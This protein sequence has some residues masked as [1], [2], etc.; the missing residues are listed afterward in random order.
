MKNFMDKYCDLWP[1]SGSVLVAHKGQIILSQGYGMA[2]HEYGVANTPQTK[3]RICSITKQFTAMAIMILYEKGLLDVND[4]A[5]GYLDDFQELDERITI[6]HLLTHTSGLK[7]R[8]G[9]AFEKE[10]NASISKVNRHQAM[11]NAYRNLPLLCEPGQEFNYSNFGYF[12]LACIVE[13]VSGV[14]YES[15][16]QTH[17]FKPLNMVNTGVERDKK[18]IENLATGYYLTGDELIRFKPMNMDNAFGSGDIY[19]TVED[20]YLWDR[21]LNTE[22]LVSN[23]TRD[24]IFTPYACSGETGS[25]SNDYGYGWF[26][27]NKFDECRMSH[28]GG[29]LGFITEVHR[30]PKEDVCIIILSNYGFT[31]VYKIAESLSSILFKS[32]HKFP[33]K[34][35]A[36]DLDEGVFNEYIGTYVNEVEKLDVGEDEGGKYFIIDDEYKI[37][38][39]PISNEAF[40]HTWIDE[41]YAFEKS[42]EGNLY[43]MGLKKI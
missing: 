29:G 35:R 27:E 17:I 11:F 33:E 43:F 9:D 28:G 40:H 39:Y 15:F 2:S 37:P 21:A 7:Y 25:T 10:L 19:S 1:F 16:L 14:S 26:I 31:A 32:P 18:I 5:K 24:L 22:A 3:H 42:P 12:L 38:I 4:Q 8:F 36:F 13:R 30:Y 23:K 34:P 20:L 6:H 41:A